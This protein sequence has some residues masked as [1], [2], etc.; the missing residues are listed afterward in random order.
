MPTAPDGRR[1]IF[2]ATVTACPAVALVIASTTTVITVNVTVVAVTTNR[3][4]TAVLD[5]T[6]IIVLPFVRR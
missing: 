1:I 5:A 6:D 3:T 4:S 2:A